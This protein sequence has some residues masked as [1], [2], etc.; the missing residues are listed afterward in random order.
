MNFGFVPPPFGA[1]R[2]DIR[3]L[4]DPAVIR[5]GN[6]WLDVEGR[7]EDGTAQLWLT[8]DPDPINATVTRMD[9]TTIE[10]WLCG[11][12][13]LSGALPFLETI[14]EAAKA[15]GAT[16]ARIVGREGWARVL[17]PYGWHTAGDEL[18]KDLA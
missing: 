16:D 10:I 11:G 8:V 7:L 12:R 9:G 3:W 15:A 14:L 18:V 13:V 17:A 1:L 2:D 5:G 4:L 6:S